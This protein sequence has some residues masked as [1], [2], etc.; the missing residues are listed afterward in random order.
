MKLVTLLLVLVSD[1][2]LA[3]GNIESK[4]HVRA[5]E[6]VDRRPPAI[7]LRREVRC[8]EARPRKV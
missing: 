2:P 5:N 7:R 8:L 6:F 3:T 4:P 1:F